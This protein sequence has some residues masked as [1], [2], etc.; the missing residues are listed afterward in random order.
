MVSLIDSV[1]DWVWWVVV[2]LFA[3]LLGAM[4]LGLVSDD[5]R[6]VR[7]L[8]AQAEQ[9]KAQ[10]TQIEALEA[11]VTA[12]E[13]RPHIFVGNTVAEPTEVINRPR[14][15]PGPRTVHTPAPGRHRATTG[16]Q[17]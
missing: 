3:V 16:D 5:L 13:D 8:E 11:R 12:L 14:P 10:A 6:N 1:P 15:V 9:I 2:T 7:D 4:V 17:Q